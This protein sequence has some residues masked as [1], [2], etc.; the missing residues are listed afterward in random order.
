[1]AHSLN[2]GCTVLLPLHQSHHLL[3]MH[4]IQ[5]NEPKENTGCKLPYTVDVLIVGGGIAG[6][7]SAYALIRRQP[8][9]NILI[10]EKTKIC[11]ST[12]AA[13]GGGFRC[14]WPESESLGRLARYSIELIREEVALA[15]D[16]HRFAFSD[17]GYVM[18]SADPHM[19][20]AYLY[21]AVKA[22]AHGA[23][24]YCSCRFRTSDQ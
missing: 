24:R 7:S 10:I 11:A 18:L 1:M 5:Q 9:L 22:S 8:Q 13:A 21:K 12:T 3:N 16:P 6:L 17:K 23:G 20:H 19:V 4:I 2:I 14:W 15:S